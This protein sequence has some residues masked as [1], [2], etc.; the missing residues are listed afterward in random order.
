MT[1]AYK[2]L[3][4]NSSDTQYGDYCFSKSP[5]HNSEVRNEAENC[6]YLL[7]ISMKL[8]HT[9]Q[10]TGTDNAPQQL[11]VGFIYL[12]RYNLPSIPQIF[13]IFKSKFPSVMPEV[14]TILQNKRQQVTKSCTKLQV[15]Y[16]GFQGVCPN[17]GKKDT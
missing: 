3:K 10:I 1:E 5:V 6:S 14:M 12:L 11:C 8:L 7:L 2:D 13:L 16:N 9:A 15:Q 17:P 4:K